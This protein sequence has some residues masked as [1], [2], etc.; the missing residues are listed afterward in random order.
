MTAAT[1]ELHRVNIEGKTKENEHDTVYTVLSI[2]G[3]F[4]KN[5]LNK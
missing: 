2:Y 1:P 5:N 3:L 4:I